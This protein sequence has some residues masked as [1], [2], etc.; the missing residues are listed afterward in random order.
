LLDV[1]DEQATRGRVVKGTDLTNADTSLLA[2]WLGIPVVFRYLIV[3]ATILGAGW[4]AR[5]TF[6]E[7]I[8]VA[9]RVG[10]LESRMD[11]HTQHVALN[12]ARQEAILIYL[13]CRSVEMDSG[14]SAIPCLHY[15]REYPDIYNMLIQRID[16]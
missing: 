2:F 3:I 10:T 4:T 15:V 11:A 1:V 16:R 14:R 7:W 13:L 12:S 9:G 5:G 8:G 6:S